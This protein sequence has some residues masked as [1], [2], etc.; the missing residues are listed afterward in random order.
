MTV[1][2]DRDVYS[3]NEQEG[4]V[5]LTVD[6]FN[7]NVRTR[8]VEVTFFTT[9]GSASTLAGNSDFID[10]GDVILWVQ[11]GMTF[12]QIN[13]SIT[14]DNKAE[15]QENFYGHLRSLDAILDISNDIAEVRI[16]D[17]DSKC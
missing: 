12:H 15:E 13:I 14:D 1:G 10:P 6:V 8:P 4:Y 2:F 7:S 5:T 11:P 16:N 9:I 17:L 3:V